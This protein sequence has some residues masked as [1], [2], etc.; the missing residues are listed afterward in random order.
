M[1]G[2]K[3]RLSGRG[4]RARW[5][6]RVFSHR[7]PLTNRPKYVS[8]TVHGNSEASDKALQ[9]FVADVERSR[10][11]SGDTHTVRQLMIRWLA[12]SRREDRSPTT[13]REHQRS[14][15]KNI[16]PALGDIQ[17]H[18]LDP[19][20]LTC[21][22]DDLRDRGLAASTVRRN[23][24]IIKAACR[25]GVKRG[26][27]TS[28]PA[29]GAE[30]PT[31]RPRPKS[32][33][34]PE[35]VQA[36]ISAAEE[37][38][39]DM[40]TLIALAAVTGARRGELCGLRWG[41]VDFEAGT[42]TIERSVAVMGRGKTVVKS[43]KTHQVRRLA[44]D[45]FGLEV[46]NRQ[47]SRIEDRAREL[48]VEV[49]NQTPVLTYDLDRPISPDACS[50]YVR[51]VAH[52]VGVDCHLH[53]LRHFAASQLI[54]A[55]YDARTVAGRLGHADASTTLRVYAHV[56]PERDRAAAAALGNALTAVR[57]V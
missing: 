8:R 39:P 47:R 40:A 54:G 14:V 16:L 20:M 13:L 51:A 52:R 2:S 37:D 9:S 1:K 28:N 25:F 4:D 55:G 57:E 42:V 31:S 11:T 56:L 30:V 23:H 33:P 18:R 43:T 53:A 6:L 10:K 26:W 7:D 12:H 19:T 46:F 27:L 21:F 24:A 5:E 35:N 49:T 50:H 29:D 34:T 44:L 32:V 48:G 15:E 45:P 41:D 38:D 22:Y 17:L 36:M 3:R